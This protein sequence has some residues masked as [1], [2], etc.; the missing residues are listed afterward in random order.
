M[1]IDNQS[2]VKLIKNPVCCKRTKNIDVRYHFISEKYQAETVKN[3]YV[4]RHEKLSNIFTK[5]LPRD[6]FEKLK[7]LINCLAKLISFMFLI[8]LSVIFIGK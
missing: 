7:I 6:K 4:N 1:H 5:A 2:A 3:D 8:L